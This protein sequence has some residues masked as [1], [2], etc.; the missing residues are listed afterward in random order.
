MTPKQEYVQ[1]QGRGGVTRERGCPRRRLQV[2]TS[3]EGLEGCGSSFLFEKWKRWGRA[4]W[5]VGTAGGKM[6]RQP[7]ALPT[8][9]LWDD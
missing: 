7:V 1:G 6:I 8:L 2:A 3:S 4:F 5:E 9:A